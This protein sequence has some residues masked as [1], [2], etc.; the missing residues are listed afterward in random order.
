MIGP[1]FLL[2][3]R[4]GVIPIRIGFHVSIL[5][6]SLYY[7]ILLLVDFLEEY[8]SDFRS[9]RFGRHPNLIFLLFI[10]GESH[11]TLIII[12]LRAA[13]VGDV[14]L[15]LISEDVHAE[16]IKDC[17]CSRITYVIYLWKFN[18]NNAR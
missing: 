11:V 1:V 7:F 15:I 2:Y 18:V 9:Q 13:R 10:S 16:V 3:G 14:R 5:R 6:H 12:S 8:L 4:T 17:E